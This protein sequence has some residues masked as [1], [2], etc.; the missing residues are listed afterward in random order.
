MAAAQACGYPQQTSD[1]DRPRERVENIPNTVPNLA[2]TTKYLAVVFIVVVFGTAFGSKVKSQLKCQNT[3]R[4]YL[5][6]KGML[7]AVRRGVR[8]YGICLQ[9]TVLKFDIL[10]CI[11]QIG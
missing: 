8:L 3:G 7:M 9:V 6:V 5:V 1:D 10:Y 2:R 4:T 11:M